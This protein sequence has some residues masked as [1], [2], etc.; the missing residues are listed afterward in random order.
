MKDASTLSRIRFVLCR[1]LE[2]F[3]IL[4]FILLIQF[5]FFNPE[6]ET[7]RLLFLKAKTSKPLQ[8]LILWFAAAFLRFLLSIGLKESILV[9]M[10]LVFSIVVG[11]LALRIASPPIARHSKLKQ[12]REPDEKRVWKLVA[13]LEGKGNLGVGLR[14]N[15]QG[16][17]DHERDFAPKKNEKRIVALG[18]SFTFG[19]AV[20]IEDS[21]VRQLEKLQD[22]LDVINGGVI[23]Y[24]LY[25]SMVFYEEVLWQYQAED[26]V[27][28]FYSDD[29]VEPLDE[30]A[31]K[32]RYENDLK[33]QAEIGKETGSILYLVNL[34]KNVRTLLRSRL[35]S[36]FQASWLRTV[37]ERKKTF[38]QSNFAAMRGEF[39]KEKFKS[40]LNRLNQ[41]CASHG[42]K[43][44]VVVI[45][46]A[47]QLNDV[48]LQQNTREL[49]TM[50]KGLNIPFL[51]LTP[52]FEKEENPLDLYL[53]PMDAHTSPRGHSLIAKEVHKFLQTQ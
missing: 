7:V 16:L 37:G 22:N 14:F 4:Q 38:Y 50:S 12:W 36:R 49:E 25:Q 51:D 41:V 8:G 18:D 39:S 44:S 46:D 35:R 28:F 31:A 13:G 23:G 32:A 27:F 52:V 34:F 15:S 21:F 6:G 43:L 11:E 20:E 2:V 24:N 53:F 10:S 3:L 33:T 40:N 5:Y 9:V 29:V 17:R 19:Y 42:A 1:I 48:K 26:V 30:L 47:V 45:P